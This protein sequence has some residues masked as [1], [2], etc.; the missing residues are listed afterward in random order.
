[1]SEYWKS[2][3]KYW[4]KF[5]KTFIR[6]TALEK[7]NHEATPKHQS[8]IQRSLRELHK[9]TERDAREKQ[10][11]KDEVARLNG[12]VQAKSGPSASSAGLP[13]LGYSAPPASAP[14]QSTA[15][16]RKRNIEQLA[17]MGV[18][19]PEEYRKDMSIASEWSTVSVT[20]VYHQ[21]A[22]REEDESD[23]DDESK[24]AV[25]SFGVRKRKLDEDDE[26]L[27]AAASARKSWGSKFKSYPGAKGTDGDEDLDALLS[28]AIIKKPK[29]EEDQAKDTP[30]TLKK[31]ESA[32]AAVP[33]AAVPDVDEPHATVKEEVDVAAAPIVFKKRKGK[34]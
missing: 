15:D 11:A 8:S 21:K 32:D 3:P 25:G 6:D 31:E 23:G 18:A 12:I 33:L 19:V 9:G 20:P 7:K 16:E 17:A 27:E 5:C 10:R 34:R 1:M 24:P 22:K 28:G 4:C 14:R 26:E 13:A 30:S 29:A 2:T